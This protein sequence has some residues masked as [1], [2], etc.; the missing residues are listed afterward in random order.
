MP[1][2]ID[3]HSFHIICCVQKIFT[4]FSNCEVTP[5]PRKASNYKLWATSWIHSYN[6]PKVP[7]LSPENHKIHF[8]LMLNQ[9]QN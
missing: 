9:Q 7:V 4:N 2:L 8:N 1:V 5:R 6:S 3:I